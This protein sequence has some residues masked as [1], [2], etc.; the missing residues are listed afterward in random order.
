MTPL[1][2][3]FSEMRQVLLNGADTAS[4][5]QSGG[6]PKTLGI[7]FGNGLLAA[8]SLASTEAD[9]ADDREE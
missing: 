1:K 8:G 7:G 5:L 4:R 3:I 6:A 9:R 2:N